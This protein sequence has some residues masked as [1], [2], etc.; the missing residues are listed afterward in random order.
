MPDPDRD[1]D[2]D[3]DI[4]EL[5]GDD[6]G[7]GSPLVQEA[8]RATGPTGGVAGDLADAVEIDHWVY[9]AVPGTGYTTRA[10][11]RGLNVSLYD[12]ALQGHYT[13]IR[14]QAVQ[15][16]SESLK[17]QM[18]HPVA[19]GQELLLSQIAPGPTDEASRPTFVN[20]TAIVPVDALRSGRLSLELVYQAMV[21]FDASHSPDTTEMNLLR[22]PLRSGLPEGQAFGAGVHRYVSFAALETLATRMLM[23]PHSRTLLLCRNSTPEGR[24]KTLHLILELL[25]WACGLPLFTSISDAPTSS[26][27]N[28]FNLVVAPRG[29]RADTSWALLESTLGQATLRRAPNRDSVYDTLAAAFFQSKNLRLAR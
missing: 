17:L 11:S 29:V 19:S 14:P 22:V 24:I 3:L 20:H 2:D 6:Q 9:G 4:D 27:M 13:P 16:A 12:A 5:L 1:K 28:Y 18:I 15:T 10:V 26:A 21:Q 7:H 8:A 23:D 25:G